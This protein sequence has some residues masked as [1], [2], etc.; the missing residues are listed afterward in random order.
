MKKILSAVILLSCIAC[1]PLRKHSD[2]RLYLEMEKTACMGECPVYL[3]HIYNRGHATLEAREHLPLQGFYKSSLSKEQWSALQDLVKKTDLF[4]L[5]DKYTSSYSD[6]P[7][8][9]ITYREDGNTK[10]IQDYDMAPESLDLLEEYLHTLVKTLRWKK[11]KKPV[12][13]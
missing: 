5:K 10:R 8:T 1:S 13:R 7:T 3:L 12:E 6:L 9:Y 2:A 11:T 4:S